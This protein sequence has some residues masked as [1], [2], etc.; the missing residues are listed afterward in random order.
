[1]DDSNISYNMAIDPVET[2][3]GTLPVKGPTEND[4]Q[5]PFH[6]SIN[7]T[8][9]PIIE[10]LYTKYSAGFKNTR[11]TNEQHMQRAKLLIIAILEHCRSR[12]HC[13]PPSNLY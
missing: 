12:S 5:L 11:S 10:E 8:R 1:M 7:I 3:E 9:E 4:G 6:G 2:G 13:T